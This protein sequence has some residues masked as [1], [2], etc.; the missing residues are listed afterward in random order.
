[1]K[2]KNRT[3]PVKILWYLLILDLNLTY[4]GSFFLCILCSHSHKK[5]QLYECIL[6][7]VVYSRILYF[8]LLHYIFPFFSF[9]KCKITSCQ[10]PVDNMALISTE[11]DRTGQ[12][13]KKSNIAWQE[14]DENVCVCV[15]VEK[16]TRKKCGAAKKT[17]RK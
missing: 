6:S 10:A 5:C 13:K 7:L 14:V 15:F 1:M 9:I 4:I 3:K 17:R 11:K 12:Y 2:K 8:L 16:S